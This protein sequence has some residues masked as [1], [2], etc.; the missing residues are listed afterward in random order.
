M[1]MTGTHAPRGRV[2]AQC[3]N[4]PQ[5]GHSRRTQ[6]NFSVQMPTAPPPISTTAVVKEVIAQHTPAPPGGY[7]K[8]TSR[9]SSARGG[10]VWTQIGM[11][12]ASQSQPVTSTNVQRQRHMSQTPACTNA[13]ATNARLKMT[14]H[15]VFRR[16]R[17]IHLSVPLALH[18]VRKLLTFCAMVLIA[19]QQTTQNVAWR[20]RT[21]R[22]SL[23]QRATCTRPR[24]ATKRALVLDLHASKMITRYVV[25]TW[26]CAVITYL[27]RDTI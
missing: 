18:T 22:L 11:F 5:A 9:N 12:A 6:P 26:L 3:T 25:T 2:A 7:P 14:K 24:W 8:S 4:V 17:A 20:I 10:P 1:Q 21:A 19:L 15:A 23:V 13:K 16:A 27:Q